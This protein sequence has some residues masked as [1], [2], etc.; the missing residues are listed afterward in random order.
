[1]AKGFSFEEA[2]QPAQ[3]GFSFEEALH[4]EPTLSPEEQ[5]TS[6]VGQTTGTTAA[7]LAKLTA[8]GAVKGTL[9]APE[10]VQSGLGA[11]ARET[12]FG[13]TEAL[14]LIADPRMLA[15]KLVGSIGLSPIFEEKKL[16]PEEVT[17]KQK[18]AVDQ[19]LTKGKI[20][21][22]KTLTE[23]GNR[24]SEDIESSIS[25]E[26]KLA[27]AESQPTGN[28]LK[29]LE[30]GDFSEVSMGKNPTF[31]GL[32]GQAAKVFGSAAPAFLTAA[33][34][35]SAGPAAA[36]GFGQA[37]AEGVD[38]ARN[39]ISKMSD[40]ELTQK[41]EYFR[42][43]VALGYT[44]KDAREM[45]I[46]KAGD[47][48]A[49]YQGTVGALGGA[50]TNKLLQ[51]AFD[52]TLLASAKSRLAKIVQGTAV[53]VTEG[54][55]SEM[56]EGIATDLGIDKSVVR[57]IGVDSFANLVLGALGEGAPGTV[58]GAIARTEAETPPTVKA[59][60]PPVPQAQVTV[61][62]APPE[63]AQ[64]Q[65]IP[66]P[67]FPQVR[68]G[69]IQEED[70]EPVTPEVTP[71]PVTAVTPPA[72]PTFD[73]W[74]TQQGLTF[75]SKEDYEAALPQL[76]AQYQAEM[77]G[78]PITEV[79]KAKA[80]EVVQEP[81]QEKDLV[82]PIVDDKG[83]P[84]GD[85]DVIVPSSLYV[86]TGEVFVN[87]KDKGFHIT[88]IER[89]M[90]DSPAKTAI[91]E[92]A[93]KA[94]DDYYKTVPGLKV[95]YKP[96]FY[97]R[98]HSQ[99]R[100]IPRL[101]SDSVLDSTNPE[102]IKNLDE[103][104]K[105]YKP[106]SGQSVEGNYI[107]AVSRDLMNK[108][109][110][111]KSPP[112]SK[113]SVVPAAS[114]Q[115]APFRGGFVSSSSYTGKTGGYSGPI[116][117]SNTV[118]PTR[119]EAIDAEA[120]QIRKRA[121]EEK[122]TIA[123]KW[124]ETISPSTKE[125]QVEINK[126]RQ[127]EK[128]AKKTEPKTDKALEQ[129]KA[130]LKSDYLINVVSSKDG[131]NFYATGSN[132]RD[133]SMLIK[134]DLTPEEF[135]KATD[136]EKRVNEAKGF[137]NVTNASEA[138]RKYLTPAAERVAGITAK[139]EQGR[140]PLVNI[141]PTKTQAEINKERQ[142]EKK[143]KA[144]KPKE[145]KPA[146]KVQGPV[147]T[148]AVTDLIEGK[149]KKVLGWTIYKRKEDPDFWYVQSPENHAENK[150]GPG[151]DVSTNLDT[152]RS[153][154]E[155]HIADAEYEARK[156]EEKKAEKPV[157]EEAPTKKTTKAIPEIDE[158]WAEN[159]KEPLTKKPSDMP[160]EV[161][162][163]YQS[164]QKGDFALNKVSFTGA[165]ALARANAANKE[166][167]AVYDKAA[168][169]FLNRPILPKPPL[170]SAPKLEAPSS[171]AVPPP[172][173]K[174]I[175]VA[176]TLEDQKKAVLSI[177]APK[178]E[179][180][181]MLQGILVMPDKL[182]VT[183]GHRLAMY[184]T[185]TGVSE[186]TLLDKDGKVIDMQYPDY[187]R[188]L[189]KGKDAKSY[190]MVNATAIG[191]YARGT[192]NAYRYI[193]A[194]KN[195]PFSIQF[196]NGEK[197]IGFNGR[198]IEDMA[199]MFRQFGY[200]GF[201]LFYNDGGMLLAK[202]P[203]GK[204]TQ[205]VM[206]MKDVDY[207]FMPF[208]AQDNKPG[209]TR[210]E[211]EPMKTQPSISLEKKKTIKE[212][213][214]EIH[215]EKINEYS[216][217]RQRKAYLTRKVAEGKVSLGLQ[218]ELSDLLELE[219]ELK[220]DV[221]LTT[222]KNISPENFMERAL[223]EYNKKNISRDV[224]DV[225]EYFY[226]NSPEILNGIKLSVRQTED[227][228]VMG[229]FAPL[230]RI[231]TL[232]KGAGA[233]S[234]GTARHEI[235]HS[236]EQMMNSETR[237][238]VIESWRGALEAAIKQYADDARSAKYF[239]AVLDFI[240]VPNETNFKRAVS[241]MPSK[242]FY[243]Y[244]NPSEYW[245][246][247]AEKLMAAKMGTPW[248]KFVKFVKGLGERLK[249][250]FGLEND[251]AIHKA[252]NDLIK[253]NKKR[254]DKESLTS[255]LNAAA[256]DFDFLNDIKEVDELLEKHDRG[257]TP[258]H[259]SG[260]VKDTIMGGYQKSK[261][262]ASKMAE[263]PLMSSVNMVGKVDR[264][265]TYARNKNVW[266]GSG[267]DQAD[268]AKYNG[269]L[270][271]SQGLA[272]ASVAVTNAIHAGHVGTQVMVQGA[273]E[274]DPKTQMFRAKKSSKSLANVVTL[275]HDLE[276]KLGAQRAANVV[277]AYFE[278]K[279]SRSIIN[280]YLNREAAYEEALDS[281]EDSVEA[282]KN[283]K[284]IE[285]AMQ[286][287]NMSD[288]AIDD[289]IALEKEYPELR[290]MMD[291]WTAV[292][293]NMLDMM[294]FSGVISKKRAANLRA[295]ED[296]V[297]WYRIMDDQA[298]IH[299][300]MGVRGMTNVGQEKKFREG[301]VDRDI[302]DIVDN[303]I[304]NVMM[305][306]RNSM[307]NYAANRVAMEYATRKENGK[308]Q[309]YPTEGSDAKG[310]RTNI[311]INGRRAI[312]NIPDPLVAEAVLGMENIEI[313]MIDILAVLA[314]GLRRGITTFPVFQVSQLFMDAPTAA[315][316]SGVKNPFKLMG[317]TFGSFVRALKPHDPIVDMLRSYGIGGYQS[318]ART[319]EKE[320]KLEIGL[321]DKSVWAKA[322]KTLDHIGDASDYAQRRAIY[323]Q[324]LKETGDEMQA[325][326]QA[327]NV[328][329]FLKRGSGKGAQFV[330][331]TVSFMNAYAQSIDVLATAIAGGGLKGMDRKKAFVRMRNTGLLLAGTT[332]LYC[333][334]VGA[335]DEYDKLDDQTKLR[336]II[337]PG[338]KIRLPMHTSASFFFK[339]IPELIYNKVMKEGTKSQV[340]WTRF[341]KALGEAAID[342]LLGPNLTP[343]GIKPV[344]EIALNHNFFTGGTVTPKGMEKLE[345]FRQ[346]TSATSELGKVFSAL[347]G[348]VLNP[349]EADHLVRGLFGTAGAAV[350]YGSN[351][352]SGDR[353]APQA[354]DNPLYGSFI[355]PDVP[356][357]REDL[358]YDLKERS[359]KKYETF[360]DL[361]KKQR[362]KEGQQY[363]EENKALI[364]A[365][366]FVTQADADLKRI[367]AEIRR[368][369]DLPEEKMSSAEKRAR[370]TKFQETKNNI[371]E[372]TIKFRLRAGL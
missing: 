135:R 277:N 92:S 112:I 192:R 175:K 156:A 217:L 305:M 15:N 310:V 229:N 214:Q 45:T 246:V 80:T 157:K 116:W 62:Q 165:N 204:L 141:K 307:K 1:M 260:E 11:A 211:T 121:Q 39:Y 237:Q 209:V 239:N 302:D 313:P 170:K 28:I 188:V 149:I 354:K 357:G 36:V 119:Q 344:A 29:A 167:K 299:T 168:R 7:D 54:G 155:Q 94:L 49:L 329:D 176:K 71:T 326:I 318:S 198:Y 201:E 339:A 210:L 130:R 97:L 206:S 262:I 106:E 105:T 50:F 205:I 345:S 265:I 267:L 293:Q 222:P 76:Q 2:L 137:T 160:Q 70:V 317:S 185:D 370:I 136:L 363:R 124:L 101:G 275:K 197:P 72:Q 253:G 81:V 113:N 196:K 31:L 86:D 79:A 120:K 14:N 366:G 25:P 335:D 306:T 17:T 110:S 352:F 220:Q 315:W 233:E 102:V 182:V 242:D 10:A 359:D 283:L 98:S 59:A 140:E 18:A 270:R 208:N 273:L 12:A 123:L 216:R 268:F 151:D 226:K 301:E 365:H 63:M 263:N 347:T 236:L 319:P 22:L 272:V 166:L 74:R 83:K 232:Y 8:A 221:K 154:I 109:E 144:A 355:L 180:R 108:E 69:A 187:E 324:V 346:Y 171:T 23:F 228:G 95:G 56:A 107:H 164:F 91:L 126:A 68:P 261:K 309:L 269:Q 338:T 266:F 84:T 16:V 5:V 350:M 255:Y 30:T 138:L 199:N 194:D 27:L 183:D 349:I 193:S 134:L 292:N 104:Y 303:M 48:A 235:M 96:D 139:P 178:D 145:E 331:R 332:I 189:D 271:N 42:N 362:T 85:T 364:N 241:I 35:K 148:S 78:A 296:Y 321:L 286:K 340:D 322:M 9:G 6:Q 282:A 254:L 311:I 38:E 90:P 360:V 162:D 41:S 256:V 225:I 20:P 202:S 32:S 250:M 146:K 356:R 248:A 33:L 88:D 289:F 351:L 249:A 297:P 330:T 342:S 259:P 61:E 40:E 143:A 129:L 300:P 34:T 285:V 243:Q 304:H 212:R 186:K 215:D 333:M 353:V 133:P 177:A 368:I 75:R 55:L 19:V 174:N 46:V 257:D 100:D 298:D 244:I 294:E 361:M 195:S 47:T 276:E 213:T 172:I 203:D 153:R 325:L 161:F 343:T 51:G 369:S 142:A 44:P 21:Q 320:L 231:V 200:E 234:P 245:A 337:I 341:K 169:E 190:G 111:I 358:F 291:N 238:A 93:D 60:V 127:V 314:N 114:I 82:I 89:Y 26:M 77:S 152:A 131:K 4:P 230:S 295:I 158:S 53:G 336:N 279:R 173:T 312:V 367:N 24:L 308:I 67:A 3:K 37:G 334:A 281:G 13:P 223:K 122:N 57:E 240:N 181:K 348:G 288:E 118:Y 43:L 224:L 163:Q 280:E 52:K 184:K 290:K 64:T 371:L 219:K 274:F 247:N 87:G 73:E 258:L 251:H 179:I 328:I 132:E 323:K 218:R 150:I 147:D 128:K 278:A 227:T 191:N 99:A 287:V 58:R 115:I 372:Q 327:N 117:A 284:N 264:A 207:V 125:G 159:K 252:F 65:P 103:I 66:I 316:V